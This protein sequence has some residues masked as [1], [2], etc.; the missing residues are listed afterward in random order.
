MSNYPHTLTVYSPQADWP[1]MNSLAALFGESAAPD[2]GT[3]R[4]VTHTRSGV[5]YQYLTTNVSERVRMALRAA[6]AGQLQLARPGWD[7][8]NQI[9]LAKA[10]A[11]LASALVVFDFDPEVPPAYSGQTIIALNVQPESIASAFGFGGA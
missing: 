2:L 5:S 10:G 8:G 7:T 1:G 3:F 11:V 6:V 4:Y 9:D